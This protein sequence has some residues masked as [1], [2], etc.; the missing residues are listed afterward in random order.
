[1]IVSVNSQLLAQEL[2]AAA[3]VV[4]TKPS[5]PILGYVW[6][7]AE[8]NALNFYGTDLEVG[9]STSCAAMVTVPGTITL[10]AQRLLGLVEQMPDAEVTL[11]LDKGQVRLVCG[12]FK[13]RVQ[14]LPADNFPLMPD[15]E[16][17]RW[18][19]AAGAFQTMI[20]K[21]AYA[22]SERSGKY[23]I[24][25]ALLRKKNN[26]AAMVATDGK[27]LAFNTAFTSEGGA[28]A[29]VVIP[30]KTLDAILQLFP[31]DAIDVSRGARHL[32]FQSGEQVL[33]SRTIEQPFPAFERI[34]PQ[35]ITNKAFVDRSQLA[36]A[37]RRV[38]MVSEDNRATY[39]QFAPG[40]LSLATS[41]AEVGDATEQVTINYEGVPLKL[42]LNW[43]FV[44][45][46][47]EAAEGSVVEFQI[48]DATTPLRV[49]DGGD[50]F[51]NVIM[52]MR[53]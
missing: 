32:F 45:D 52:A 16:G 23:V 22:I 34:I 17:E 1:V 2:R 24:N 20:S 48:K 51:L 14:T 43:R 35:N 15:V 42:C 40:T 26:Q 25:A 9:F 37:I 50:S 11:T 36:S 27:R 4:A 47:L 5:T 12:A 44:L 18:N 3:K 53:A 38:G 41:S 10:P 19:F 29:D 8:N 39:F 21:V 6:I 30:S 13:G 7:N 46:F 31:D 33:V 28:D 49:Q